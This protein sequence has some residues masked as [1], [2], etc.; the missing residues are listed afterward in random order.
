VALVDD[1]EN[2]VRSG[3]VGTA[4]YLAQMLASQAGININANSVSA[5]PAS[6]LPAIQ[7][8]PATPKISGLPSFGQ[9]ADAILQG[10]LHPLDTLT[11]KNTAAMNKDVAAGTGP[12]T[13]AVKS[14][15]GA[16]DFITDIPRVATTILGLI[17]I[18]AGIFALSAGS[19]A[20]V[21]VNTVHSNVTS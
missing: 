14:V 1:Y 18:I 13:N 6:M 9:A 11:G 21:I 5:A 8:T 3:D 4:N 10:V 20:R 16:L 19:A 15:S 2:A 7:A 17:L 12:A